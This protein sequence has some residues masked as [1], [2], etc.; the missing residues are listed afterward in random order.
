MTNGKDVLGAIIEHEVQLASVNA[1][2]EEGDYKE[3]DVLCCGKCRTP[4]E[5]FV[6]MFG[7]VVKVPCMCKCK[8]EEYE[9]A[10]QRM[11]EETERIELQNRRG[12]CFDSLKMLDYTFEKCIVKD[13][14]LYQT[15]LAYSENFK[16]MFE[17]GKGLMFFGDTGNGKSYF[18]AAIANKVLDQGYTCRMT[19]FATIEIEA[20]ADYR[21]R[22]DYIKEL[23]NVD[24]LIIDDLAAERSTETMQ[25]FVQNVI[26]RR[27]ITHK[28]LIVTTN[29]T[30]NDL[31]EKND[32]AKKRLYSRLMGMTIPICFEG[33]DLRISELK[34]SYDKYKDMLYLPDRKKKG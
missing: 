14:P 23:T 8:S 4:K 32:I 2:P 21:N 10:Q 31:K 34:A 12:N 11:K 3:G 20:N 25:Q 1:M 16:D 24:L 7:G 30:A 22:G 26:D 15:A 17:D 19:N 5:C 9:N 28:P 27:Y 13:D 29:L 6:N 18:A 33:K